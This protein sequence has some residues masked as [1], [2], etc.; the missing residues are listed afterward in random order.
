ME[1]ENACFYR[2]AHQGRQQIVFSLHDGV[3]DRLRFIEHLSAG[4]EESFD[5]IASQVLQRIGRAEEIWNDDFSVQVLTVLVQEG[6]ELDTLE[7]LQLRDSLRDQAI[8][9]SDLAGIRNLVQRLHEERKEVEASR[10]KLWNSLAHRSG[11]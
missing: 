7:I 10:I 3:R 9:L 8:P 11:I 1:I 4:L 6:L 5:P 2:I